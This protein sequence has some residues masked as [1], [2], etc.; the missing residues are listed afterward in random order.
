VKGNDLIASSL[1]LIGVLASGET[2]SGAITTDAQI[3]LQ[4]M[5]DSWQ[6]DRLMI[7]TMV[8]AEFA[9]VPSQQTYTYGVGGNF[10]AARP[11]RIERASIVSLTNP[12]Q[13][14]ELPIPLYT[15]KDWQENIPVKLI[16][17]TLP[18]AVYDDGAFPL[19]N[20]SYWPI[21]TVVVNTR[22]YS[23][24]PLTTFSD[25]TTDNLFPPGY[26]EALRYNL[27]VRLIAE[28]PGNFNPI[29]VSTTLQLANESLARIKSMN[30][31]VVEASCDDALVGRGGRY[32]YFSDMPVGGRN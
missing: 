13:P 14:L 26:V 19:R 22:L 28:M 7:F 23:W 1:R 29:M 15:D 10:N 5:I 20:L 6:A 12:A 25:L 3:V 27:A 16:N 32:N 24:N 17:T 8:I 18:Q 2:P 4:Q 30:L 11:A 9:L 21:P 31:P